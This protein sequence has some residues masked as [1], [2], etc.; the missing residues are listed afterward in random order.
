M[1]DGRSESNVS[2]GVGEVTVGVRDACIS[3]G[4][5]DV[6]RGVILF[7]RF[8]FFLLGDLL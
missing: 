2:A 7:L 3:L 5:S 1:R 8:R 4:S 6:D